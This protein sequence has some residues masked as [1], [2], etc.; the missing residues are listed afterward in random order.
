MNS[1]SRILCV[2]L[3]CAC[4]LVLFA[5]PSPAQSPLTPSKNYF[6]T[7]DYL[8]AGW[9]KDTAAA[10]TINGVPYKTG[11]IQVPDPVQAPFL[12]AGVPSQVPAGADIVAAFLYWETVESNLPGALTGKQGFF[13]G[14][15]ITGQFL[16]RPTSQAP[17]S[18]SSGGCSGSAN[19]SKTIQ[20]YEADV[21][22]FL[23]LDANGNI[24][25]NTSYSVMLADT[26]SNG[27]TVPFTLGATL[28]LVYRVLQPNVAPNLRVPLTSIVIFDGIFAPNN[29][30]SPSPEMSQTI[31]GFYQAATSPVAKITHIVGA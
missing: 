8:V 24:Q 18:W 19:G 12:P 27:N 14:Y 10:Q 21:R 11:T 20:G 1:P 26:G 31:N 25:P 9:Q 30:S 28:V 5:Q 16:P 7:G 17:T 4:C 13:N 6:V 3:V 29:T 15:P 2:L 23:P 22:P